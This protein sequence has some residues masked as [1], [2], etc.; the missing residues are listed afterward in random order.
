MIER[1][2]IKKEKS[3]KRVI[4]NDCERRRGGGDV[5]GRTGVVVVEMR[6]GDV[7]IGHNRCMRWGTTIGV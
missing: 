7:V 1:R 5:K 4:G 2:G 3:R 6:G